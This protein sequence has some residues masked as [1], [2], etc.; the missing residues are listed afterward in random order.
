MRPVALR[1]KLRVHQHVLL[2]TLTYLLDYAV[3]RTSAKPIPD[4]TPLHKD[5]PS[6]PKIVDFSVNFIPIRGPSFK[7]AIHAL[8]FHHPAQFL[9]LNQTLNEAYKKLAL[10]S[11]EIKKGFYEGEDAK[12]K[13]GVRIAAWQNRVAAFRPGRSWCARLC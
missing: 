13:L 10:I 9:S 3:S 7:S 1:N 2:P 6:G 11:I 4:F 12:F 5:D 8:F